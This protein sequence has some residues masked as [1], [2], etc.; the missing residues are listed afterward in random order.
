MPC[1]IVSRK[2]QIFVT[3]TFSLAAT[4]AR[5]D[6]LEDAR[7]EA[8]EVLRLEP[9]YTIAGTTRRIVAFKQPRDDRHFFD[10][11]RKAGLSE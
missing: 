4:Y 1:A 11:L 3:L 10:G 5:L 9:S 8:A 2:R 7:G 6:K